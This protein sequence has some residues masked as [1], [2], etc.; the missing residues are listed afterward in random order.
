MLRSMTRTRKSSSDKSL[1]WITRLTQA[2][3]SLNYSPITPLHRV[4]VVLEKPRLSNNNRPLNSIGN[5]KKLV[6]QVDL[7]HKVWT[8]EMARQMVWPSS[9]LCAPLLRQ[10]NGKWLEARLTCTKHLISRSA[11]KH[12]HLFK[13]VQIGNLLFAVT[14][15]SR[16][17]L[18][19]LTSSVCNRLSHSC[20]T[21]KITFPD[22]KL[23]W[24]LALRLS[25]QPMIATSCKMCNLSTSLTLPQ[26]KYPCAPPQS[27]T[28]NLKRLA[29]KFTTQMVDLSIWNLPY[30]YST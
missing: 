17:C 18:T 29:N 4:G 16:T 15:P 21:L 5:R 10:Q 26:W 30:V 12:V 19:C 24:I 25:M 3:S 6:I 27:L 14:W 8:L 13:R 1:L 23:I 2:C 7:S 20:K 9:N 28:P 22:F 11:K